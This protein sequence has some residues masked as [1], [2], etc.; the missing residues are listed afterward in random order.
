M[1]RFVRVLLFV[2]ALTLFLLAAGAPLSY[3]G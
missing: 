3:G 1:S 2:G